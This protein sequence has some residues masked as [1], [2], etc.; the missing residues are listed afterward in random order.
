EREGGLDESLGL[1]PLGLETW[2]PFVFVNPDSEAPPLAEFLE[3]MPERIAEA[4]IDVGALRFL[5]RAESEYEANW[6]I[7]T[8][9]FLECYHCPVAHPGF[10]A[11]MD[12]PPTPALPPLG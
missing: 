12:V 3:D 1:V 11:V 2:G 9:N 6:K 4:G 7:C 5:S 8:E 10:S